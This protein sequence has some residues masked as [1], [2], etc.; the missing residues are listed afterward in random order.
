MLR[1]KVQTGSTKPTEQIG[2]NFDTEVGAK[3]SDDIYKVKTTTSK[4]WCMNTKNVIKSIKDKKSGINEKS[5]LMHLQ[6]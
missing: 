1:H 4:A 3:I 6:I 2:L 5:Q